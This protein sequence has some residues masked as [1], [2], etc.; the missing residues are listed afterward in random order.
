MKKVGI[1][2]LPPISNYG[3]IMQNY[4]LQ[5]VLKTHGY[6]PITLERRKKTS[7]FKKFLLILK[8]Q[9][10]NRINGKYHFK[11][12][13]DQKI[14]INTNPSAF[15]KK[16]INSSEEIFSSRALR[17]YILNNKIESVIVGS[18]QI[19]RADYTNFLDD[20]FLEFLKD[21]S[22]NS[23]AYAA[24]FGKDS[25][26][27]SN[28][29]IKKYSNCLSKFNLV[30]VREDTGVEI[31]NKYLHIKAELVLDPTML[32][33]KD[34]YLNNIDYSNITK[35]TGVYYYILDMNDNKKKLINKIAKIQN[36]LIFNCQ[37]KS[38]PGSSTLVLES[39]IIPPIENWIMGFEQANFI[40]TDSFHGTVFSIIF[41]KPFYTV[42][43]KNKGASRFYSL[44]SSL[45]LLDRLIDFDDV[46]IDN[47]D[48]KMDIDFSYANE[49]IKCWRDFSIN[50]L[51][52]SLRYK[53]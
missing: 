38:Y 27:Y 36:N 28:N 6:Y 15:K 47:I 14:I 53:I 52:D 3:G 34:E 4:A 44:L 35:S 19:W 32:L 16:Y 7:K 26:N 33:S 21:D 41:N 1:L 25:I 5:Y 45:G 42:V 12:N 31:C 13:E 29:Q 50:R 37:P 18:D 8:N 39:Y 17:E 49:K 40:I 9:T 2:T 20:F 22:I 46:N 24:S 43:N 30:S 48:L 11:P 51:M 10:I 23:I